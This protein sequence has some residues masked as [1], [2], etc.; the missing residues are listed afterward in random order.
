MTEVHDIRLR[1]V[2]EKFYREIAIEAAKTGLRVPAFVKAV[3]AARL[4]LG[5]RKAAAGK[6]SAKS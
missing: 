5:E 6:V 1:N 4:M 3:L 2:D